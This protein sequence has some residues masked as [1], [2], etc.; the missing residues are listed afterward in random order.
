MARSEEERQAVLACPPVRP[1]GDPVLKRNRRKLVALV[2]KLLRLGLFRLTS[3]LRSFVGVFC[4]RKKDG[5]QRLNLDCILT[6]L[7][8]APPPSTALASM[9][10]LCGLRVV[11]SA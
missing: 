11:F 4:V 6:N 5:R 2:R 8:F 10:S 7:L 9:E 1:Y 3:S